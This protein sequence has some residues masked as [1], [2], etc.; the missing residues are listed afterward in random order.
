MP[1]SNP[2]NSPP[3]ALP[4]TSPL[5]HQDAEHA[6]LRLFPGYRITLATLFALVSILYAVAT[7]GTLY[8]LAIVLRTVRHPGTAGHADRDRFLLAAGNSPAT[9]WRRDWIYPWPSRSPLGAR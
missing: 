4:E 1:A 9:A 7:I 3:T 5:V 2:A 6:T 8:I